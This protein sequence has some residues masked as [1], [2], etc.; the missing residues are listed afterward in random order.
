MTL[1]MSLHSC[2]FFCSLWFTA[3]ICIDYCE[4]MSVFQL[5]K[6]IA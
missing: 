4:A 1:P 6:I 2:E 3:C 5:K